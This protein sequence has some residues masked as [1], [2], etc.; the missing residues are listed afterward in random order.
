[1]GAIITAKAYDGLV[2]STYRLGYNNDYLEIEEP[3]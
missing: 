2:H 1:M 3:S